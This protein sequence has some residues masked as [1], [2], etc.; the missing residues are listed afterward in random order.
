MGID[1]YSV[2]ITTTGSAGSATGSGTIDIAKPGWCEWVY[3]DFHASA[4]ATTDV[5]IALSNPTGGNLLATTNTVTDARFYPR[6]SVVTPANAAITDGYDKI[7]LTGDLAV[8]VA[9]ADAL[10][11]CVTVYVA[12]SS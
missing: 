8:S 7:A 5:T 11:P 10:A 2:A 3:L 6:A 12:V 1:V 4:A 9:Q